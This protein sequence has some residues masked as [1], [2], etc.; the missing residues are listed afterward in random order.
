MPLPTSLT[1]SAIALF[2]L[3][4]FLL[5]T[6]LWFLIIQKNRRVNLPIL[7]IFELPKAR[8]RPLRLKMPPWVPF[9]CFMLSALSVGFILLKPA[10]SKNI[11]NSSKSVRAH[12]FADFS[13]SISA[14]ID[15][16][17]YLQTIKSAATMLLSQQLSMSSS[18]SQ[19]LFMIRTPEELETL[20]RQWQVL[21]FHRTGTEIAKALKKT[22]G[23]SEGLDL[24][25]IVSDNDAHSLEGLNWNALTSDWHLRFI[26]ISK[27]R[28]A[29]NNLYIKRVQFL[30]PPI[31]KTSD[32]LVEIASSK[33]HGNIKG[34]ISAHCKDHKLA[35]SE[36]EI[37]D[38]QMVSSVHI[39]W[40]PG[41]CVGAD[42]ILWQ[43]KS[44]AENAISADDEFRTPVNGFKGQAVIISDIYGEH[45]IDDPAFDLKFALE[46]LG[47][48]VRRY[49][50][51]K[52]LDLHREGDALQIH[53][54]DETRSLA[55]QCP[56]PNRSVAGLWLTPQSWNKGFKNLCS[57][58]FYLNKH[59]PKKAFLPLCESAYDP[60]SLQELM[61]K[62]GMQSVGSR[63]GSAENNAVA[64]RGPAQDKLL[65]TIPLRA[66]PLLGL[67]HAQLP[68]LTLEF[69]KTQNP[70]YQNPFVDLEEWPRLADNTESPFWAMT[71][72][73]K[74]DQSYQRY[75]LSN[76]PE[77][78]SLDRRIAVPKQI[79]DSS[80]TAWDKL[81][82]KGSVDQISDSEPFLK[83]SSLVLSFL[84]LIEA[85]YLLFK[86][87]AATKASIIAFVVL[88]FPERTRALELVQLGEESC[89]GMGVE[90]LS[91]EIER[92]T[93]VQFSKTCS[94]HKEFGPKILRE[95]WIW[96]QGI[97]SL[98]NGK[99][100]LRPELVQWIKRGGFLIIE[101][102]QNFDELQKLSADFFANEFETGKWGSVPVG[103]ELLKSFYLIQALPSCEGQTWQGFI[104]DKRLA[105]LAIPFRFF[106]ALSGKA[107]TCPSGQTHWKQEE[108]VR[109]FI[110]VLMVALTTDYKNEQTHV[111]AILKRI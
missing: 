106:D 35:E 98:H 75:L 90:F 55:E 108:L 22:L 80:D 46:A 83:L 57:C 86:R 67:S 69:L 40:V 89:A 27:D 13:P 62:S 48:R 59:N 41:E 56:E 63:L 97:N 72:I 81:I 24:L 100:Q 7:K 70:L 6:L 111:D 16:S 2:F 28:K 39:S 105:I 1:W 51:I 109:A 15:L 43:L 53:F 25:W 92:R 82:Q 78:E 85:I 17:E 4:L 66:N 110:N 20:L 88:I 36:W 32:W 31:A 76:V 102:S 45:S 47:L 65:F 30:S 99:G 73:E 103:H 101:G 12:L 64:W 23:E 33:T 42:S 107:P 44:N 87:K 93:S 58:F 95:P 96:T 79:S 49:D 52:A 37:H 104:Y 29:S 77:I 84:L 60:K 14:Y 26:D 5:A 9:L 38:A 94:A 3:P 50:S 18:H 21:G 91:Q 68:L 8:I 34:T 74:D 54:I 61:Y 11:P 19:Q 10:L 71:Q